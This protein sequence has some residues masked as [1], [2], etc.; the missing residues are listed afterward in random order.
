MNIAVARGIPGLE[1]LDYDTYRKTVDSWTDRFRRWLPTVEHAFA[2]A[3][4]KYENDLNFFRLGMLAQFLDKQIGIAYVEEQKQAQNRGAKDVRYTDPGHLLVHG[5]I[6]TKRGTC[7]TM[8][9]L[10]VAIGRR[11]GWPVA[12]ACANSHYVCRY[13]DG[14]TVH[15]IEATDTGRGGFAAGS[16]DDYMKSEGISRRAVAVGSDLRKLSAREM[17]GVFIQA[18]ARHYADTGKA[19][20][21][22]SDYA[23]AHTLFPNS[24]KIYVGLAG[25][26]VA[27][28]ERLFAPNEHGHPASLGAYLAGRY[29]SPGTPT[30]A[31]GSGRT[32]RP[33]PLA[34]LERINELNRRNM[35]RLR[36]PAAPP[37]PHRP[38]VPGVVQPYQPVVPGTVQPHQPQ[39]RR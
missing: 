6:D 38:V 37:Q 39:P 19:I 21:A 29:L 32:R 23:L 8:P 18:R 12:L 4:A 10:H 22:A 26:L 33:D 11:L 30:G 28:G 24:R 9:T 35:Q 15:N 3:P 14:K 1:K 13:D 16:D 5:L 7:G 20:H 36:H 2:Q 31:T 25:N 34:E 17:L 27:T